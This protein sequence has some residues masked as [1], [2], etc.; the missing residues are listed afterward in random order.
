MKNTTNPNP[1]EHSYSNAIQLCL[2]LNVGL[3]IEKS[4]PVYSFLEAL[5][6]VNLTKFVKPV[7]SNNTK[8]H[9]RVMLLKV[10]LFAY[11]DNERSLSR[12]EALCR[13]DIR[14]LYLSNEEKPSK[15]AFSRLTSLLTDSI[16]NIFYAISKHIASNLMKINLNEAY[17][18][19]TK[20]EA[21]ANKNTFV[22]KKR[23]LNQLPKLNEK[24]REIIYQINEAFGYSYCVLGNYQSSYVLSIC[25]YLM[26]QM[27]AQN[28]LI[29][30]GKGKRKSYL[31]SL[32][33][34][35]LKL[36]VKLDE[37]EYWL[38]IMGSRNSCSKTDHDATF[39]AT[40]WDYYNQ[41][42]VTRPCYNCQ[43]QV[44]GGI[45]VNAGVYQNPGDTLTWISFMEKFHEHYGFYPETPVADAGYGSYDNYMYNVQHG[46]KLVQKYNYFGKENDKKFQKKKYNVENWKRNEEGYRV[47]P[48][49]RVFDV[50]VRDVNK[51][52][53]KNLQ[54]KQVY[55]EKA[56]CEGCP[57]RE[58][59][60]KG[61]KHKTLYKDVVK[62]EFQEEVNKNL[63]SEEGRQL[64]KNRCAQVE[65]AFGVIKQD[66]KFTRFSRKGLKNVE[67]EFYLVCLGLNF[68]R[69]H[70]YRLKNNDI[71]TADNLMS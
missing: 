36:A 68:R 52:P 22:Y 64:C 57:L 3:I 7:R 6:G 5:Q 31:Q 19:G 39:M 34:D 59:C 66:M 2:P 21:N 67:M 16:E 11:M 49:G 25:Q 71:N 24:I 26:E 60:L 27:V 4:D 55:E 14:Y 13:T 10:L 41:S 70:Q 33:D 69:Y 58:E 48:N 35:L 8:S 32:Y 9:D 28:L 61:S 30:Y 20:L 15:M 44:S 53:G 43:I 37:Y 46:I 45:I 54:I 51:T 38:S 29:Q 42:G 18:D 65:G 47:C 17:I 23:I 63:K 62:D 1:N 50:Y 56:K 12:I 40:K